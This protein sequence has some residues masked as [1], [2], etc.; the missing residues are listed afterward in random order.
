MKTDFHAYKIDGHDLLSLWIASYPVS[1]SVQM[2]A[3]DAR[4]LADKLIDAA[5]EVE[6]REDEEVAE[7][8]GSTVNAA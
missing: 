5:R 8:I 3:E 1:V 7:A 2:T 6:A 4:E